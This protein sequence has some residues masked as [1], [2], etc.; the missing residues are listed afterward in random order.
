M[1]TNSGRGNPIAAA[2]GPQLQENPAPPIS[3]ETKAAVQK[4]TTSASTGTHA[5]GQDAGAAP[6]P[7]KVKTEKELEKER[8]KLEKKAKFEQKKAAQAAAAPAAGKPK[9]KKEKPGKTEEEALPPYVEDTPVGEKKILKPFDNPYY[10]SYHPAA[11]ESAWYSWWEKQGY[12]KPEFTPEGEVKPEGSFVVVVPPPNVTGALHMGHAL[13]NSLQD[14]LIRWNR[15]KGKTTLWL[16]GCD[17]AGIATQSVVEKMLWRR[18]QQ[19]RHDLGREKFVELVYDWKNEYHQKINN[20]FRRMGCSL[21]WSR[22]AFTMDENFSAAVT[23]LFV[24]FHEE[25]I[26][27]RANRLVNWD[28]TLMTALSNLEVD[29]KELNGRTLIDVPGY[30]RKVE[31]GIIVHFKYP[32]EGSE[33]TIEVATTRPET[34]LG[35]TGIAV[36]P[37]DQR[38]AHLVGKNAIHPFIEG[39]KLPIVA[40]EYVDMEFGTGAVKLTPAHDPNDFNLG[41]KHKL[42]FVNILTDDG[43]MNENAGP[44]AGKKRFDVRYSIQED[45]KKAGLYVDKKDNP[46]IIPLSERSKDVV[47]PIM[48]PQWWMSMPELAADAVK[49]VT[50]GDIKIR[51]ESA[52]KSFLSWMRNPLD[53]CI[54]RQLWWGHQI[55]CYYVKFQDSND[56]D[57]A[58]NDLWFAGRTE[59]EALEKAK[60]AHPGRK[61][62]LERDP[63]VLDTWFSSGLWPFATLGW[64]NQTLDLDKL[65]PTSLL[66]T[67]W[68]I[69]FFWVARMIFLGLKLTGK[70]PFSEVFCHSLIRDAEGRK[71]SKSLGNVIDPID[72]I[73]GIELQALHEKLLTGNLAPTELKRA[74]AWQKAAFPQGIP[75]CGADALHF[76]LISY[77]TG[78]GD[79]NFDVKVLHGYRRFCNKIWNASKYVLGKIDTVKNFV[80]AEKRT[81]NGNES[82]AELWMLHKLNI[83]AKEINEAL[84]QRE[85]M[86]SANLVYALFYNQLCDVF[87]ENSKALISEGSEAQQ[88]SALQTLYSALEGSLLLIS[89]F[90]PFISEELWQRLPRRQGDKTPSIMVARYPEWQDELNNPAAEAAY[91]LVLG[92]SRGIRSLLAEYALKDEAQIFIQAYDA[93][94]HKTVAEQKSSIRSLSG[95][96]AFR[97]DILEPEAA[98]PAGCVA[99]TVSSSAAVFLHV[100]DRVDLDEEI[101]KAAKKLERARG[102]VDKQRKLVS[103]PSYVQK[104][105]VAT[106]EADKKK[107]ADLETELKGFEGTI[108]QFKQLKLE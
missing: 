8:K 78:G 38:Y 67:G 105:A 21:D 72:I 26:I 48:K 104:V 50:N 107:L 77:T 49:A 41:T 90:M 45:L 88:Q 39:R 33:E 85:F 12:F 60:K 57:S 44:Y 69:I 84:E 7:T 76:S 5:S 101:A 53:W 19:T 103:D 89:P 96:G 1:A 106:Q 20:A 2:D 16:P 40:D 14:L 100:K 35:D 74:T 23:E 42:D 71:M 83:A 17:H 75:E 52:E 22:E 30:D 68:D 94:S 66:E 82:L 31:F 91:D 11:V 34:M 18:K 46:M 80:P 24:R 56:D 95:K 29:N 58:N 97:I 54:S 15:Q 27:Y 28:S 62:T 64:P 79:I 92:S 81:L 36:H 10:S 65:Y 43:L 87:I 108:E 86:K 63:D 99:F 4:A 47:E 25:K 61:F 73:N 6:A 37:K 32:L 98:R 70:V 13:G 102:A 55:P 93:A 51:P 9:E 3:G 59:E